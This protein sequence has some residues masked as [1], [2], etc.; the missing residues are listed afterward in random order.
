MQIEYVTDTMIPEKSPHTGKHL[1]PTPQ[2]SRARTALSGKLT[3]AAITCFIGGFVVLTFIRSLIPY[4][5]T[6]R[7]ESPFAA[8]EGIWE[9]EFATYDSSGEKIDE[10]HVRQIYKH[11]ALEDE[12]HQKGVFTIT[13]PKTGEQRE[14]LAANTADF[15]GT[16]LVCRVASDGGRALTVH[17]GRIEGEHIIWSRDIPGTIESFDEWIDGDTYF[18]EGTGTYG[19]RTTAEPLTFVGRYHRVIEDE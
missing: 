13:D 4:E 17:T 11:L 18:I 10:I 19:D 14:E 3:F 7:I 12:F 5:D 8:W 9:G 15:D 1:I 6:Q 16:N 2:H